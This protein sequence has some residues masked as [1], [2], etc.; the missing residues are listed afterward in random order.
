VRLPGFQ[1]GVPGVAACIP[2]RGDQPLSHGRRLGRA[3]SAQNDV[4]GYR[5]DS[6]TYV[7]LDRHGLLAA[8]FE[9]R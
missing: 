4:K 2:A 5:D 8:A 3:R 9:Q 1:S 6:F 7:N